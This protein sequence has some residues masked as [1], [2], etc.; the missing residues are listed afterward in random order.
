MTAY[1]RGL[2]I[3]SNNVANLNT[4]G[5]KLTRPQYSDIERQ[6]GDAGLPNSGMA[7][8]G[9]TVDASHLSFKA[10]DLHDTGNSL[11]AAIDGDGFFIL[12]LNGERFYTRAGQFEFDKDGVL[13]DRTTQGKVMVKTDTSAIQPFNIDSYRSYAPKATKTVTLSGNLARTGSGTGTYT[14]PSITTIDTGGG[15]QVLQATFTRDDT[16]PLK[17]TIELFDSDHKSLGTGV[18]QLGPDGTPAAD[19]AALTFD[20]KPKDLPAYTVTLNIGAAGSYAGITSKADGTSSTVQ[21]LRQDGVEMGSLTDTSFDENGRLQLTYS[22]GEKLYP[23]TLLLAGFRDPSSLKQLGNSLFS[24]D[25][26]QQDVL[27]V[28]SQSGLGHI[29]GGKVELSNVDL[30]D[31]FTDLIVVQRGYQASSQTMSVANEMLQQLL[32]MQ[33]GR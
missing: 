2:D 19:Q 7:G 1:S 5:F 17:W 3:I 27:S 4:P 14:V 18:V 13:V 30:T 16:D 9:V 20:V 23:A 24:A 31:Q 29:K 8:A 11:D 6:A 32:S 22:N 28:P 26:T 10:G 25:G 15:K 12:D 21:M 33:S